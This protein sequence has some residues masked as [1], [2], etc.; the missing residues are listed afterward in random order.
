[1]NAFTTGNC[2]T[3]AH[4][5]LLWL[6]LLP[7]LAVILSP[8]LPAAGPYTAGEV[9]M[10][11][12]QDAIGPATSDY[13]ERAL[14]DAAASGAQLVILRMDTPGGLDTAMRTIVKAILDSPVPVAGFVAPAGARAASAGTYILYAS[15]VAAMAPA[16]NLGAATPVQL[17]GVPGGGS[18]KEKETGQGQAAG[19]P[20]GAAKQR[21]LVNDAAAYLRGLAQLRGRNAAWAEEAVRKG[22]SLSATEALKAGVI[23]L[24]AGDTGELL[25]KLDGRRVMTRYGERTL[26]T[27]GAVVTRLAPDWRSR[28]L[29]AIANPNVA[30][31]L[32]L[33]GV[34]GLIFEFSNPG[35]LVPGIAGAIC[36]L[37][38]LYAFQALPVNYAGIGLILLG[39]ALMVAEAFAPSFGA[40]GIGGVVAFVI[41]SVILIDTDAPGYGI[42]LPLIAAFALVSAGMLIMTVGMALKSRK[43]PVVSGSEELLGATGR[44]LEGFDREGPVRVHGEVWRARTRTPLTAGQR[45]RISGREGLVLEVVPEDDEEA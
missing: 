18:D 17:V 19:G 40:L 1:M 21:T 20:P 25:Q 13:A 41:G 10:L 35:S 28:L 42:S 27:A 22:V 2:G 30:Y 32:M 24:V 8:P 33:I 4:S 26:A 3:R 34:Y 7:I 43:R 44:A 9:V 6:S 45:V 38:A 5:L 15:H 23:D 29:G 11:E 16:T 14:Q 36:L 37:L 31:L 12:I 39:M